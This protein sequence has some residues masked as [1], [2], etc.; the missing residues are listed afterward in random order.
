MPAACDED[1]VE[2]GRIWFLAQIEVRSLTVSLD[3][4]TIIRFERTGA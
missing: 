3:E 1:A 4:R 2:I